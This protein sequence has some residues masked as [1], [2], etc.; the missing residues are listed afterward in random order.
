[1]SKL[2]LRILGYTD[3]ESV[4][5]GEDINFFISSPE[6][7][8]FQARILRLICGD[9]GPDGPGFKADPIETNVDGSY[10]ARHQ[11]IHCG[12]Y[13][14]VN[15]PAAFQAPAL[16]LD[17]MV[18]PTLPGNGNAQ[19]I[20]GNFDASAQEGYALYLDENGLLSFR[21]GP[22]PSIRI[23][24]PMLA[25][26][27]YHV[28]ASFDA[29]TGAVMLRQRRLLDYALSDAI[30]SAAGSLGEVAAANAAARPFLIAGWK[31]GD[32]VVAHFNGKIDSPRVFAGALGLNALA[33]LEPQAKTGQPLIAAWDFSREMTTTC[34]VDVSGNDRHGELINLPTRAM[35]GWSWDGSEGNWQHKPG[36]YG[37]IHFHDDDLY[38]C[39]W[40]TD[41]TLKVPEGLKSGVYFAEI[42]QKAHDLIL[43][44]RIPFYV[45][46]PRD[47]ATS[48]LA[49]LIPTASYLAYSNSQAAARWELST[50]NFTVLNLVDRYLTENPELGLSVYDT[51][52][53]G[54][55][56]C[57]SSRLRPVLNM[58]PGGVLWQLSADTHITDWLEAK[59]IPYDVITDEDLHHEGIDL[60]QKYKCVMTGSHPEYYTL[61]MLDAV[62]QF[63]QQGGRLIYLG[64]NGF[65]W[66]VAY[67]AS[68]PG[69]LEHRRAE[70][71]M[72]AWISEPGEYH[73]SFTGELSGLWQRSGRPPQM[74]V[75]TGFTAQGFNM[76]TYYE[77]TPDSF[78]PRAE[79][80]FQGIGENERIGDFGLLGGGAAGWEIDRADPLLGTAP[81]T[82]VLAVASEFSP[83]Y[84]WVK[85]EMGHTH[86]SINGDS[87]PQIR[88]DMTYFET[89]NGGAVFSTS[90]ISW[91]GSLSHNNYENNVSTITENVVRR[92]SNPVPL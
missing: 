56:V 64:A 32:R 31:E 65:Y 15:D 80:I 9:D 16:T 5:P 81:H 4:A 45:R 72:R 40:D 54:S 69:V 3:K 91:A 1:M 34:V 17:A 62:R 86:S 28:T 68:L 19:V 36:H 66:R 61:E 20:L 87:C 43:T 90:S 83:S 7:G 38:D 42:V 30:D 23:A 77:R 71:G 79:F 24:R 13:A 46:P 35:K 41:F 63:T 51:H 52:S 92:F 6:R 53:D 70:D 89:P 76:A 33:E 10:E 11:P 47:R 74:L 73:M 48:A 29:S 58:R 82:L 37:A 2:P 59:R 85:E 55:G 39:A 50:G 18:W 12:S 60:L 21:A 78:H 67:R 57:Y 49:L 27:W 14:I 26:H 84:H 25:R 8:K 75:G 88:C 22:K 44:D